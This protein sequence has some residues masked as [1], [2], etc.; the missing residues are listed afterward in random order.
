MEKI[1]T[2]FYEELESTLGW[3]VKEG[4][5]EIEEAENI[6]EDDVKAQ[7]KWL[8]YAELS[9][10]MAENYWDSEQEEKACMEDKK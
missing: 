8:D 1:K 7:K 6:L 5:I 2:K 9:Q 4:Y 10:A 3:W